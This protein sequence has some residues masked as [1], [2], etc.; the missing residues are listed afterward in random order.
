MAQKWNT[1]YS[2]KTKTPT[3]TAQSPRK[4]LTTV[5]ATLRTTCVYHRFT[6]TNEPATDWG[7][8]TLKGT[9]TLRA[10]PHNKTAKLINSLESRRKPSHKKTAE[11]NCWL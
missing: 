3:V 11:G 9:N 10:N 2:P 8:C 7:K 4:F 1:N 5:C 6:N